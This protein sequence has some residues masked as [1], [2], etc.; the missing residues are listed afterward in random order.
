M[1]RIPLPPDVTCLLIDLAA[2]P[3][4]SRMQVVE[5]YPF[6]HPGDPHRFQP[7]RPGWPAHR[8]AVMFRVDEQGKC[9]LGAPLDQLCKDLRF[10]FGAPEIVRIANQHG[11]L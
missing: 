2:G 9:R 6:A 8:F 4:E 1:I 7:N 5:V 11:Y 10:T 3:D